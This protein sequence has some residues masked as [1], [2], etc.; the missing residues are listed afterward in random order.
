MFYFAYGANLNLENMKGRCP[1]AKKLVKFTL[2]DYR[3]VFKGVADIEYYKG[4]SVEGVLWDITDK[5]E[6]ALDIFEGFPILY[7]KEYFTIKMTGQLARDFGNTAD[8][9]FYTMN[10]NEYGEPMQSYFDC[11]LQGY[12]AN[13]LDTDYLWDALLHAEDNHSFGSYES[14]SWR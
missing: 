11:I 9:M 3:L 12:I 2:Q 6:H 10:R 8:V 4:A 1:N 7:R 14:K 5:C 13:E